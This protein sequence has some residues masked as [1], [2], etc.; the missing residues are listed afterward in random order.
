MSIPEF[1]SENIPCNGY[2]CDGRFYGCFLKNVTFVD[3]Q[4]SFCFIA[5]LSGSLVTTAWRVLRLQMEEKASRYG[6]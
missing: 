2:N 5:M 4:N 3:F 1:C 6:E